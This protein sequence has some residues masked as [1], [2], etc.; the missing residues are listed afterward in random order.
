MKLFILYINILV[1]LNCA[2]QGTASGGPEDEE[3]PKIISI[4][5]PNKSEILQDQKIILTFNELLDPV[6]IQNSVE[7]SEII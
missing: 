6:S 3:G 7:I 4:D 2:A 1:L 5:P